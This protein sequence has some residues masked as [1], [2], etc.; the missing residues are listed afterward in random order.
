MFSVWRRPRTNG[1]SNTY[2]ATRVDDVEGF[3]SSRILLYTT[4]DNDGEVF[5]RASFMCVDSNQRFKHFNGCNMIIVTS[6]TEGIVYGG[7]SLH[8]TAVTCN[9]DLKNVAQYRKI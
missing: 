7:D 1:S 5:L 6:K 9:S 4:W 8:C 3:L 2:D